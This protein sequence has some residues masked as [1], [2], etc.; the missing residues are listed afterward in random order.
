MSRNK[1][2]SSRYGENDYFQ[3]F[4]F[5]FDQLLQKLTCCFNKTKELS[6]VGTAT[7]K[8]KKILYLT[9]H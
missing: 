9:F 1:K 8:K 3:E 4:E 7:Y 6:F 5:S 2:I